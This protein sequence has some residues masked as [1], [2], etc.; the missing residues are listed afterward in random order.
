MDLASKL[1]I[2][3]GNG[4]DDP[5]MDGWHGQDKEQETNTKRSE[6]GLKEAVTL[7]TRDRLLPCSFV[8][9]TP[10]ARDYEAPVPNTYVAK[11]GDLWPCT[12]ALAC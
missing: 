6:T 4:L 12:V 8:C 3:S 10:P 9:A 1:A 7:P 11:E 2:K 5:A